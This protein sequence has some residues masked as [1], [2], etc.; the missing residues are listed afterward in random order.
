[1]KGIF[2]SGKGDPGQLTQ[3]IKFRELNF[4]EVVWAGDYHKH[5]IYTAMASGTQDYNLLFI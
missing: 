3:R 5:K 2:I 4:V 1:M